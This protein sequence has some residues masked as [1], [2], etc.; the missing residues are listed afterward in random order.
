MNRYRVC[1]CVI[2]RGRASLC[3]SERV[4]TTVA[5]VTLATSREARLQRI[6]SHITTILSPKKRLV[7][8]VHTFEQRTMSSLVNHILS[9]GQSS[10]KRP[11]VVVLGSGVIGLSTAIELTK[12]GFH[13]I[14][15]AKDLAE[16]IHSAG[17]ASPWAG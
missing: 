12:R 13:P 16:D 7:T 8:T 17:F 3:V 4:T 6:D 14:V 2:E 5:I 10:T 1:G 15:V 11:N 9:I